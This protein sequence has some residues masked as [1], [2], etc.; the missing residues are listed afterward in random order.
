[1]SQPNIILLMVDQLAAKWLELGLDGVVELPNLQSLIDQ[2]IRYSRCYSVNPVCSPSRATILTGMRPTSH[3]LTECGYRLDPSLPTVP[4]ILKANGYITGLFGKAHLIPEIE[5][6]DPDYSCYGFDVQH[7]TE[8]SRVGEWLDWVYA[9][10]HEFYDEALSTVWMTM[11]SNIDERGPQGVKLGEEIQ[12]AR[13][14]RVYPV[15]NDHQEDS[16]AYTLPFPYEISQ[17]AWITDHAIDFLEERRT[18]EAPLFAHVSYVQ[19]HNPF[20][21]PRDF[22]KKVNVEKIPDPVPADWKGEGRIGYFSSQRYEH[23]SYEQRDWLMDRWYYLADLAFLDYEIGRL[24]DALRRTGMDDNTWIVMTSDHGELLH[25]H[26]LMGKWERHYDPCVRVPL[27]VSGP[28]VE[29]S[30]TVDRVVDHLSIA[31]TIYE[32]AGVDAQP[33]PQWFPPE[34]DNQP[35]ISSVAGR[36]LIDKSAASDVG[37]QRAHAYIES[38]NSHVD[39]S[40]HSWA[41]T[42]ITQ[43]FRYTRYFGQGGEQLFD[44]RDDPDELCNWCAQGKTLSEDQRAIYGQMKNLL[45]DDLISAGYPNTFRD[46]YKI[47][48][49]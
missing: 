27:I 45:M 25:D 49:W 6:P 38:N 24:L 46:L 17:T 21:P 23:A 44:L 36:S 42:V 11:I 16:E 48:S 8:D 37:V 34:D 15:V 41:R 12:R 9:E 35:E 47:G 39:R 28:A 14:Q 18:G 43:R 1:M 7:V 26:G 3:G 10:H 22:L 29:G 30:R 19:P 13:K 2:G 20:T 5:D 31:P 33:L 40:P 4:K 32:I